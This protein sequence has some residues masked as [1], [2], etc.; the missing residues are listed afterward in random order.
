[1]DHAKLRIRQIRAEVSSVGTR[2]AHRLLKRLSGKERAVTHETC[3]VASKQLVTFAKSIGT[4][5]I[6]MEDLLGI[7]DR[8]KRKKKKF[9]AR[10]HRWPFAFL[11]YC[12][13]YKAIGAG[14]TFSLVSPAY[15]SQICPKCGHISKSN[16][17]RSQ[18]R[19]VACNHS[20]NADRNAAISIAA[21]SI[22]WR[23]TVEERAAINPLI[24]SNEG[25]VANSGT[26]SLVN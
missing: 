15:T 10:T 8:S 18:F 3:H 2:S 9:R 11:Q 12:I 22:L 16:R 17:K 4:R 24:V 20:D 23:Q 26:S 21:R 5:E 6:V 1:L 25:E 13:E 14:I 7:R 19:C